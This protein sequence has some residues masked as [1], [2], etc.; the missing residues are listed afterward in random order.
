MVTDL[1]NWLADRR[2]SGDGIPEALRAHLEDID[3]P[4]LPQRAV[5]AVVEEVRDGE[6]VAVIHVD[7]DI[8]FGVETGSGWELV[9]A[10]IGGAPLWLGAEPL[11]LL[12]LGSDARPG[13]NQLRLR[14]DSIHVIALAPGANGGTIVGFPRDSYISRN[15]ILEGNETAG[16]PRGDL[17]DGSI[18]WTSLMSGRGP[19]IMLGTARALTG[20]PIEGYIATGFLGFTDLIA[21][22]G[23]IDITLETSVSTGKIKTFFPQ[24]QQF[25]DAERTLLL[26][27]IR[28]TVPGGDFRRSLN[29]GLIILAAMAT[30]QARGIDGTPALLRILI[31]NTFTDLSTTDLLRF[32][33]AGLVVDP[34]NLDNLVAPG[35]VSAINGRSVVILN[36]TGV[37]EI[38]ADLLPDGLLDAED[39]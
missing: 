6:R 35:R 16:L 2:H 29:Q 23:G 37:A 9:G 28:K 33:V 32:A 18:K 4:A 22:I 36:E 27:R 12:V 11:F 20:L 19:E 38:S 24:G 25:L 26:A 21:A 17:P 5:R 39:E 14:A 15:T 31:E 30:L 8:L 34:A 7:S 13:Q 1:Y 3:I 10:S